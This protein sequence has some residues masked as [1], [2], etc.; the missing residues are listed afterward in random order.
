M[1]TVV[2]LYFALA[3]SRGLSLLET[4]AT[5]DNP[6]RCALTLPAV[7]VSNEPR[8]ERIYFPPTVRINIVKIKEGDNKFIYGYQRCK[9]L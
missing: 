6:G 2:G 5:A 1:I 4:L 8:S 3:T 7:C 9:S